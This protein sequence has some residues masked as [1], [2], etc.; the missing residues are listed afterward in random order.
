MCEVIKQINITALHELTFRQS[1][2]VIIS[3]KMHLFELTDVEISVIHERN[4]KNVCI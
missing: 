1:R 2:N 4:K 3:H